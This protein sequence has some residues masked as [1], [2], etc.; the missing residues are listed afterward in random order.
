MAI[1]NFDDIFTSGVDEDALPF[2]APG[3][4]LKNFGDL[5]TTGDLAEG[6]F[7]AGDG[8]TID[9]RASIETFGLGAGGIIVFGNDVTVEN[10]GS[11]VTHGSFYGFFEAFSEGIT[12]VGDCFRIA[13]YGTVRVEGDGST[14]MAGAG[15]DGIIVNYGTIE[16]AASDAGIFVAAGD[17]SQAIN[18]GLV[19]ISGS[20]DAAVLALGDGASA[21]NLGEIRITGDTNVAMSASFE[22]SDVTNK[23]VIR[24][25]ADDVAG[26]VGSGNDHQITNFGLVDAHGTFCIGLNALGSGPFAG[27]DLE[28]LNSGR[29][30]MNGDL[31]MGVAVGLRSIGFRP[32]TGAEVVN[33]GQIETV[34]NGAAGVALIGDEH[35]LTNS[36]QITTKGAP[37]NAGFAQFSA[38]G[39]L[40]AGDGVVVENTG[41]IQSKNTNSAAVELNVLERAG[42]PAADMSSLLE[43]SGLIKGAGI[44]V[45]SGAGQ[46]TVVNHG[47]IVGAVDLGGGADT[48]TFGM[49][50]V[51]AGALT[52]G[53]GDDLVITENS[54]GKMRIADFA[55]GAA[56][57]DVI[58]V[59]AFF[60]DFNDLLTSSAQQGNDVVIALD[61]NDR[62][63]LENLQLGALNAGDFWFV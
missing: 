54:G 23:G 44:A 2:F 32:A 4:L 29:V 28:I 13:N 50:G 58:D 47:Q 17:R 18:R 20:F 31:A 49:G 41:I 3:E 15:A 9:N 61:N 53:A 8:I 14:A 33:T 11:V 5:T 63:I 46:E 22:T 35:H 62:L 19:H 1:V 48:F 30:A 39:V 57:G 16:G 42:L 55:A 59:S 21:L 56:S 26:M 7:A 10:R 25:T 52:L 45:L 12:V 34:G 38:A 60:D 40:V 27:I 43:N 6:I 51:L 36:G 24:I 37:A